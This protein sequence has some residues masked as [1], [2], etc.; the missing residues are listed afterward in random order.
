VAAS[1]ALEPRPEAVPPV[2]ASLEAR[3]E[4]DVSGRLGDGRLFT[5][6][7]DQRRHESDDEAKRK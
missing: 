6:D 4:H 3:L 1:N 5:G 2:G 7:R